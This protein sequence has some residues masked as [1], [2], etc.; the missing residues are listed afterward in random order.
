[1]TKSE[2]VRKLVTWCN[3]QVGTR[4]GANNYNQYAA[5]P[6]IT[7]LL[8]WN[9]QNQPWCD[10]FTDEA[11]VECFGLQTGAA[12]TYQRIGS[13]SALCSA[14]AQ[15]FKEAGAWVNRP[16]AG[17]VVFFYVSG[18]IN[19]QGIV[20]QVSG[21]VVTTVE[22]NSSDM[23]AR[24]I[25]TIGSSQIA[26]YGRP[27]WELVADESAA[28]TDGQEPPATTGQPQKDGGIPPQ[29]YATC[30]PALPVLREGD[31]GVPV[32]RLQ[33]LLIGRGYY[34][35]GRIL[36][37]VEHPDGEFGPATKI[38][39]CDLQVAAKISKD[40]EVGSDTW[41]VLLTT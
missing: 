16:E 2:A 3:A 21:N 37:G 28:D 34:C 33:T 26:G 24:R 23:V 1:M 40:G 4:E 12:M 9:A 7:Q 17:D 30:T 32:E 13:G 36:R 5:D 6:R 25:Y 18:G 15:F 14:S 41:T 11:F 35:G 8:G 22:G 29:K 19:H 38:A 10:I 31:Q 27:K 39:V 20:T